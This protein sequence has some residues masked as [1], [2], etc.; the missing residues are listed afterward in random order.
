MG[1]PFVQIDMCSMEE[2]DEIGRRANSIPITCSLKL[3]MDGLLER[4]WEMMA[5]VGVDV[6]QIQGGGVVVWRCCNPDC[7][8]CLMACP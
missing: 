5:L 7:H 3:N 8:A 4:I 2:V 1:R 6:T